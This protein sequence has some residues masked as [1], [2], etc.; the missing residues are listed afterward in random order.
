MTSSGFFAPA[1]CQSMS[2]T[3]ILLLFMVG[4]FSSKVVLHLGLRLQMLGG[5][6]GCYRV[7]EVG[8]GG[9]LWVRVFTDGS[10]VRR[11][12]NHDRFLL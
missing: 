9:L 11:N 2:F 7:A 6:G 4:P 1:I 8:S 3:L 5:G 12:G 10:A